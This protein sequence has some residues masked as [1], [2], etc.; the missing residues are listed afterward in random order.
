MLEVDHAQHDNGSDEGGLM[1]SRFTELVAGCHRPPELAAFWC[2]VLGY[3]V[4]DTQ[5]DSVEISGWHPTA[6]G[7]RAEVTAPTLI[8]NHVPEPTTVKN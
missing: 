5:D 1:T 6:K 4:I 3:A 7:V 2:A 8:F